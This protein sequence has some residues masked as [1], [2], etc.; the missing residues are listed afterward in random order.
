MARTTKKSPAAAAAETNAA[1]PSD[2]ASEPVATPRPEEHQGES[3]NPEVEASGDMAIK[4]GPRGEGGAGPKAATKDTAAPIAEGARPPGSESAKG[5]VEV[6]DVA[7]DRETSTPPVGRATIGPGTDAPGP[8]PRMRRDRSEDDG[9]HTASSVPTVEA[10]ARPATATTSNPASTSA[11]PAERR[12]TGF[13]PLVLGGLVAGAIGY[14]IPTWFLSPDD[15]AADTS[16]I[17]AV[18]AELAELAA[19]A[20]NGPAVDTAALGDAQET[21]AADVAALLE[22]VEALEVRA[23][24]A[25]AAGAEAAAQRMDELAGRVDSLAAEVEDAT[26]RLDA[27]GGEST[28]AADALAALSSR[29]DGVVSDLGGRVS[30]VESGLEEVTARASSVEDEAEALAREAARNQIRIA[31]DSGA[32]YAEPLAVLGDAPPGLAE[33]AEGGVATEAALLADFP[34]LAREAL[35]VA[36]AETAEG[37]VGALL[38]SAFGARSLEPREGDD[39]DAVLS[40]AEA[41]ARE[42]DLATAL[43]EIEALPEPAQ[44]VFDDWTARAR[45]RIEAE[46][47]AADFLQDG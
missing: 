32:P 41:A 3:A 22:R 7:P 21:L 37:G 13:L 44:A 24:D 30:A 1:T 2:N 36:R 12:G 11:R 45:M 6:P 46:T 35:R 18:E 29:L 19:I 4:D 25:S 10:T 28:T 39:P 14:A 43:E 26:G 15:P 33:P 17:E 47:A 31:L 27:I 9:S 38:S 16:R 40:R 34:E 8:D 20:A 5:A 42:G 23:A